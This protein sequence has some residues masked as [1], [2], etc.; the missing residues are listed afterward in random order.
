MAYMIY[1]GADFTVHPVPA[2][3]D[4]YALVVDRAG[5]VAVRFYTCAGVDAFIAGVSALK[6][7]VYDAQFNR[8]ECGPLDQLCGEPDADGW[9]VAD[10]TKPNPDKVAAFRCKAG[11]E[12]HGDV[13]RAIFIPQRWWDRTSAVSGDHITHYKPF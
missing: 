12:E 7:S 8:F 4:G 3:E 5:E 9:I 11:Y 6:K 2:G 13:G 1:P 10:H